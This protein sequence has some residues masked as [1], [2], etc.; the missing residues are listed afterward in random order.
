MPVRRLL[1]K[2]AS[3][4]SVA[5]LETRLQ[6]FIDYHNQYLAKPFRWNYDGR[7]LK[8]TFGT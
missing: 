4:T 8:V 6:Q 2:R 1:N 5:D 7:L 3:F